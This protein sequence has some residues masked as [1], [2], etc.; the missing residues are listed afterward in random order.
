MPRQ[1]SL[2]CRDIFVCRTCLGHHCSVEE[3]FKKG[4]YVLEEVE[5]FCYMGD[6]ISCYSGTSYLELT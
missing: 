3:K 1:V 6:M 5:K 4:E 2:S